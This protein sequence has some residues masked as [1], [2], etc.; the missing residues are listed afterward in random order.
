MNMS[1]KATSISWD[2]P[3]RGKCPYWAA[4]LSQCDRWAR[5]AEEDGAERLIRLCIIKSF[6]QLKKL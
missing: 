4:F 3:F 5:E 2:S 6:E 1:S